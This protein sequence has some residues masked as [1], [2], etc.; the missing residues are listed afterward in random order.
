[1]GLSL[2]SLSEFFCLHRLNLLANLVFRNFKVKYRGSVLGYVWT[3]GIPT[4]QVL[5]FY[6]LYQIIL[7][8]AVP[9]YLAFIVT[10]IFPWAF[11]STTVSEG[12]DSLVTG[13][14]LLTNL[15]VPIQAFPAASV[16]SN[17]FSLLFSIPILAG[18]LAFNHI[19]PHWSAVILLPLTV[20]LFV[21]TY[22]FAF[23]LGSLYVL[24]RDLKHMFSIVIQL[25]MYCT[26]IVYSADMIPKNFQWTL[27]LNPLSGYFVTVRDTL[28]Y[29]R[30]P[31]PAMVWTF[32]GWTLAMFLAGNILRVTIG[33]GLVERI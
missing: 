1:M 18:V 8:I 22:S 12:L 27:Y 5:V 24:F 9:N 30:T 28:L 20:G 31:D 11:F 25:W 16:I 2:S 14:N 21:F 23:I 19:E 4:L 6:F 17:F 7:H 3:L 33:P 10:G 13:H 26:P 32:V 29:N 15:P